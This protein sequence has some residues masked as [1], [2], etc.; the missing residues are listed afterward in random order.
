MTADG[1]V[2][3]FLICSTFQ[4]KHAAK[5]LEL[6]VLHQMCDDVLTTGVDATQVLDLDR[7]GLMTG[8]VAQETIA[9]QQDK[10]VGGISW[11]SS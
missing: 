11:T 1:H 10:Q 6:R 3:S 8:V 9:L 4:I 5:K 7:P 2:V